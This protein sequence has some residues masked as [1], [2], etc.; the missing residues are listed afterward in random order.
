MSLPSI[1]KLAEIFGDNAKRARFI[2]EADRKTLLDLPENETWLSLCHCLP[3]T[4]ELRLNALD[5]LGGFHGVE[6]AENDDGEYM[7]YL[8]AGDTYAGTLVYWRGNYRVTTLGDMVENR[9]N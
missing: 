6:S 4:E 8:N 9:R 7:E 3:F 5:V 2:L 1:K